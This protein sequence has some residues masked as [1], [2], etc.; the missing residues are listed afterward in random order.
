MSNIQYYVIVD[1]KIAIKN[2][3]KLKIDKVEV[4]IQDTRLA[5]SNQYVDLYLISNNKKECQKYIE[6]LDKDIQKYF[7][8]K[9]EGSEVQYTAFID[10]LGFSD[11]IMDITNDDQAENLYETFNEII[12]YIQLESDDKLKNPTFL[13][14]ITLKYSWIS[15]TFVV[16]SQYMNE[17][18]KDNENIIKGMMIVRLSIIIAS[19]H[20]FVASKFGLILRGGISSKYSCITNNFILGEGVVKAHKLENDIA[21]YPRVIFEQNI[22]SDELHE[23]I[24]RHYSDNDLDFISKDCDGYYFVNYLAILQYIPPMIGK[25][26][27]RADNKIKEDRVKQK[28]NLIEKYQNIATDGLKIE[29]EKIRNKYIWLNNYL[30]RLRLNKKFII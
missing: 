23:I 8:I 15:D 19:I 29:N 24:T 18:D 9:Q 28:L 13:Q 22:I 20:H 12:E 6:S 21:V 27:R 10:I 17:V 16:S 26:F 3:D 7:V 1:K 2:T 25:T 5:F 30:G 14:D 4:E 11:Y